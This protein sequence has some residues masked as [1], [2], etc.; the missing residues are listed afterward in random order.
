MKKQLK[1]YG[2]ILGATTL[3]A[4]LLVAQVFM[5]DPAAAAQITNRSLTLQAGATDGGSKPGGVVN[6]FFQFTVPGGS[7]VGSIKF[8][9]CTTAAGTCTVPTGLVTT[10]ATLNSETGITGFT[11]NN[12]TNGAPYLA[13]TPAA[14]GTNVAATFRLNTITNPTTANQTFIVRIS[15]YA[16]NNTTGGVTDSGNVAASTATQIIIDGTMPE[17]LVFCTGATVGLTAG[18]P[19]CATATAGNISFNQLFSPTDTATTS[20]QM[21]ASTNAGAGY[22]ITVNG[23]TM[24]SGSNTITGMG[25]AGVGVRGTSQFG[26]NLKL[27]TTATSTV[28][29]GAE[30]APAANGTNYRGQATTGYNTA[31]TFKFT[32]GDVVA[33]S[34]FGGAGGSDAQIFT[35]SYIVNVPGSQ[36]AGTYTSTLTYI[37]TPTF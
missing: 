15:T 28:A 12:S 16:T 30:V 14:V 5:P 7:T 35:V 36:P 6:H 37:C 4:A 31:D 32:T 33:D 22:S 17:S 10:S 1:A 11:I 8:E 19:D 34:A 29:I 9:Y 20:S 18:V 24:T 2:R 27:N 21:A 13:R 25:T 26:L 23:P 3:V